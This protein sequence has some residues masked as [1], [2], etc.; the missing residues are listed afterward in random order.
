VG[1]LFIHKT[2]QA[3]IQRIFSRY[4]SYPHLLTKFQVDKIVD[5]ISTP[6]K[7]GDS[8]EKL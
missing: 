5:K 1:K 8:V 3:E 6:L 2:N 7:T 4:W